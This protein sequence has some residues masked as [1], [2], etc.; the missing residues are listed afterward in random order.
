MSFVIPIGIFFAVFVCHI[1]IHRMLYSRGVVTFA[2]MAVYLTGLIL[3]YG[4]WK[5]GNLTLPLASV[6]LYILCV[7]SF[8]PHYMAVTLEG[9][10]PAYAIMKAFIRKKTQ[11]LRALV[12]LFTEKGLLWDRIDA[13]TA[14]GL[15]KKSGS[16]FIITDS[17]ATI[18]ALFS[19]YRQLFHRGAGG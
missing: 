18:S 19:V 1:I 15:V 16:R 11:T 3:L 6:V 9:E 12:S 8:A 7:T 5:S 13:L 17:G 2:S 4:V 14:S 10:T